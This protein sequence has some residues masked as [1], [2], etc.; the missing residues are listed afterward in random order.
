MLRATKLQLEQHN[1]HS[2]LPNTNLT[3]RSTI[4]CEVPG[5]VHPMT[6][7]TLVQR[8]YMQAAEVDIRGNNH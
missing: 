6:T 2:N 4:G 8:V 1:K 7:Y 5:A 3:Y